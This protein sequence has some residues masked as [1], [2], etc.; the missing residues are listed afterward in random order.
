L[1]ASSIEPDADPVSVRRIFYTARAHQLSAYD[2]VYL[3]LARREGL[4]LATLDQR[5]RVAAKAAGVGSF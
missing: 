5:L 2:A 4:P 3:E 1:L